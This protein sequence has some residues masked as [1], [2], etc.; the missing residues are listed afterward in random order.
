MEVELLCNSVIIAAAPRRDPGL[1]QHTSTLL[2]VTESGSVSRAKRQVPAGQPALQAVPQG[3]RRKALEVPR[4]LGRHPGSSEEKN[5]MPVRHVSR[6]GPILWDG[7]MPTPLTPTRPGKSWAGARRSAAVV[8]LRAASGR[9]ELCAPAP[10]LPARLLHTCTQVP[11]FR[12]PLLSALPTETHFSQHFSDH[13]WVPT[14]WVLARVSL[15]KSFQAV[16]RMKSILVTALDG[17]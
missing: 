17:D 11:S 8:Q 3:L 5:A 1:R 6:P 10:S 2:T 4:W 14:Q 13:L 16:G 15:F 7:E 12:Q 9:Q